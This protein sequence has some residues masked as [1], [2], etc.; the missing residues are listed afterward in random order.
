MRLRVP[1]PFQQVAPGEIRIAVLDLA[2]V[3]FLISIFSISSI[4]RKDAY[5]LA[6]GAPNVPSCRKVYHN[7][8]RCKRTVAG[9]SL[10]TAVPL[11]QPGSCN[12]EEGEVDP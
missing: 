4:A 12:S 10:C 2:L 3:R 11:T 5:E 6:Y 7:P 1:I 8:R 9:H